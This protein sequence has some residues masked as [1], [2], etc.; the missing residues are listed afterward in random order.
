MNIMLDLETFDTRKSAMVVSLAAIKFD[1]DGGVADCIVAWPNLRD[2]QHF[3]RT[4]SPDTVMW[5]LKQDEAARKHLQAGRT[6]PVDV[7]LN[8]L[9]QFCGNNPVWSHSTFD[10]AIMEDLAASFGTLWLPYK[11]A[12]C[13]RTVLS[14][15]DVTPEPV[16]DAHN[17]LSDCIAQARDVA[18][19]L[20]KIKNV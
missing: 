20:R 19:A 6:E 9:R 14:L 16:V 10:F 12:R 17:P 11:Q 3:G 5:W 13:V 7:I 1:E 18:K 4:M 2:Q 15:A 8:T